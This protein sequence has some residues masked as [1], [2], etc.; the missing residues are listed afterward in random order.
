MTAIINAFGP[1]RKSAK[2]EA[3]I[4]EIMR[5]MAVKEGHKPRLP[6]IV[7]PGTK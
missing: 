2:A 4:G 7:R 5:T 3:L 6:N 1:D